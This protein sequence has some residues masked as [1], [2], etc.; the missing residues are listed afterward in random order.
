MKILTTDPPPEAQIINSF[1]EELNLSEKMVSYS[2]A[3]ILSI[4]PFTELIPHEEYVPTVITRKFSTTS[5]MLPETVSRYALSVLTSN[6]AM[7]ST[8]KEWTN[9]LI[10]IALS[11]RP[12]PTS[13]LLFRR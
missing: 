6:V 9:R 13:K 12:I 3:S 11:D 1:N 7:V 2:K 5:E 4:V 8:E 10:S